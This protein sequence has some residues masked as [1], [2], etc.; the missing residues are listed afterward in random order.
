MQD[1]LFLVSRDVSRNTLVPGYF[2]A[3]ASDISR[4]TVDLLPILKEVSELKRGGK[5]GGG[6]ESKQGRRVDVAIEG[7]WGHE[8]RGGLIRWINCERTMPSTDLGRM[9]YFFKNIVPSLS[10]IFSSLSCPCVRYCKRIIGI[11]MPLNKCLEL[12]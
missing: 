1:F 3:L 9:S 12:L 4:C 11:A 10:A 7:G 2:H 5:G 6:G 8:C